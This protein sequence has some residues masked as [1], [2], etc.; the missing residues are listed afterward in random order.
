MCE[1]PVDPSFNLNS[2]AWFGKCVA[3]VPDLRNSISIIRKRRRNFQL[4]LAYARVLLVTI[5]WGLGPD[6]PGVADPRIQRATASVLNRLLGI[7][8]QP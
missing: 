1:P 3:V 6:Y 4:R 5:G 7:S 2:S 8:P